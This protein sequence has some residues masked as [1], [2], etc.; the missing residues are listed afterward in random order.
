MFISFELFFWW[1]AILVY[2]INDKVGLIMKWTRSW[3]IF[4]M[5][6]IYKTNIHTH[7]IY[8]TVQFV[9]VLHVLAI[10]SPS[11]GCTTQFH[12]CLIFICCSP[13][14]RYLECDRSF[15]RKRT[16][17][18]GTSNGGECIAAGD[19]SVQFIP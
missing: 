8:T 4:H 5:C 3:G 17:H 11:S 14:C 7:A 9:S 18:A 10:T 1:K 2:G 6:F 16:E 19:I 13:C 12:S 15:P